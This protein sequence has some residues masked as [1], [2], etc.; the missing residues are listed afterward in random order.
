[1]FN[2]GAVSDGNDQLVLSVED[3]PLVAGQDITVAF[4]GKNFLDFV[5]HQFTLKYN[6]Q[7]LQFVNADAVALDNSAG[8]IFN[9]SDAANG[10]IGVSWYNLNSTSVSTAEELYTMTF[11][12]LQDA[13][14]LSQVLSL[15]SDFIVVEATKAYGAIWDI[16]LVFEGGATSTNEE[17][18][19]GFALFQN[20][21]NPFS[22]KTSIGFRLPQSAHATL[23]IS[24]AT[25]KV[26]KVVE[27]DFTAGYHVVHLD[28]TEL[29][30]EGVLLYRLDTPTH[31][32]VKKMVLVD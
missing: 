3:R 22:H 16:G 17:S 4:R 13:E 29:L 9:S 6:Q 21:P 24:D 26:L 32:A 1:L 7:V 15:N 8:L 10:H 11:T 2:G 27:S 28:R 30:A 25:G 19:K 20:S 23:T 14:A 18:A 5:T 12:V 31:S